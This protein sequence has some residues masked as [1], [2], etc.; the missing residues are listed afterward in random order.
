[1]VFCEKKIIALASVVVVKE[2]LLARQKAAEQ[3]Q[4]TAM[5]D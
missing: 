2:H 4:F 5:F 1:M 3:I